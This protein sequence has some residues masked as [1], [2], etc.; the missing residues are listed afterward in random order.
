M[1]RFLSFSTAI[2]SKER[3]R[4]ALNCNTRINSSPAFSSAG[5][6]IDR[7]CGSSSGEALKLKMRTGQR[8]SG[9]L[10]EEIFGVVHVNFRANSR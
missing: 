1:E 3:Q 8:T 4:L 10:L 7:R 5:T 2:R 9:N 6:A